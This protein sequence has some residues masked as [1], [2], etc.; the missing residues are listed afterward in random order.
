[1]KYLKYPIMVVVVLIV[2]G[3]GYI[4]YKAL[5]YKSPQFEHIAQN[6]PSENSKEAWEEKKAGCEP[7][8]VTKNEKASVHKFS[9]EGRRVIVGDKTIYSCEDG[10]YDY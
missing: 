5:T 1:M 4:G 6:L 3:F 8:Q 9:E 7:M 2:V 10:L